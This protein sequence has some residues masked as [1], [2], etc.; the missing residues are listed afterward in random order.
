MK[1]EEFGSIAPSILVTFKIS[2]MWD[3]WR[4]LIL[5]EESFYSDL[6]QTFKK[7]EIRC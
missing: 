7:I 4:K 1:G 6:M 2:T 5:F 3:K